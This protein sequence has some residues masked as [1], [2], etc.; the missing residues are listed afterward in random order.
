M[1]GAALGLVVALGCVQLVFQVEEDPAAH[2]PQPVTVHF[3]RVVRNLL[4][5]PQPE[6]APSQVELHRGEACLM[7]DPATHPNLQ[8]MRNSNIPSA[9]EVVHQ[10]NALVPPRSR[11]QWTQYVGALASLERTKA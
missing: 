9:S 7:R 10:R 6:G 1:Y 2:L 8:S 3:N 5:L 4:H 11:S